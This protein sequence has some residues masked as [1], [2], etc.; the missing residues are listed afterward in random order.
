[1]RG[2]PRRFLFR[3]HCICVFLFSLISSHAFLSCGSCSTEQYLRFRRYHKKPFCGMPHPA[4]RHRY[5]KK[6]SRRISK[7]RETNRCP[8]TFFLGREPALCCLKT[9]S[10]SFRFT[11]YGLSMLRENVAYYK[12]KDKCDRLLNCLYNKKI[13]PEKFSNL[14][15]NSAVR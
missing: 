6:T 2:S 4:A 5:V 11:I 8:F 1:M 15:T 10:P 12:K 3:P 14:I 9:Q 13:R 7:V